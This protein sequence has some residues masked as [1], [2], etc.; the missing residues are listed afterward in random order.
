[1]SKS[2]SKY[3]HAILIAED[4]S[5]EVKQTY[6]KEPQYRNPKETH[7]ESDYETNAVLLGWG[8]STMGIAFATA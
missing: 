7:Y 8:P 4:P 2:S 6:E 5:N 3:L 1:M